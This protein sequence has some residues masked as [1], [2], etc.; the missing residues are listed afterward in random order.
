MLLVLPAKRGIVKACRMYM[1]HVSFKSVLL[2]IQT[3]TH[4]GLLL[5]AK[6]EAGVSGPASPKA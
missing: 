3:K 6:K 4:A 5:A 2:V 1:Y